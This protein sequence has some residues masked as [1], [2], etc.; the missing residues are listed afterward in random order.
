MT[1]ISKPTTEM[2]TEMSNLNGVSKMNLMNEA[3]SRARMRQ[4]QTTSSEAPRP[5]RRVA[6]EAARREQARQMGL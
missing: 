4:P 1:R 3:L 6:M 5:A 2:N